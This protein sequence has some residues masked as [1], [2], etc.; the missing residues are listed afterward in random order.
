MVSDAMFL[1][2]CVCMLT[3]VILTSALRSLSF[4]TSAIICSRVSFEVADASVLADA[5]LARDLQSGLVR[6]GG[7]GRLGALCVDRLHTGLIRDGLIAEQFKRGPFMS[8]QSLANARLLQI[9]V[10]S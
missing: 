8:K 7:Q 5:E 2:A 4:N 1:H 6:R 9:Q 3:G 10:P